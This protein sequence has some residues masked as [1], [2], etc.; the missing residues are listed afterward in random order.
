MLRQLRC[1]VNTMDHPAIAPLHTREVTTSGNAG[2]V[3]VPMGSIAF[4]VASSC[5]TAHLTCVLTVRYAIGRACPESRG[6][7]VTIHGKF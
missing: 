6:F 4:P 3:M 1:A 7:S 2:A 5:S